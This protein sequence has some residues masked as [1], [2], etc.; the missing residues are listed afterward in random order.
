M[1]YRQA[2]WLLIGWVVLFFLVIAVAFL[3]TM[4][5]RTKPSVFVEPAIWSDRLP[6]DGP[7]EYKI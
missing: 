1:T 6:A 4:K 2:N 7:P 3:L 5:H